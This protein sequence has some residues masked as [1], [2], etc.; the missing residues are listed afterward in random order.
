MFFR[1][2]FHFSQL[3]VESLGLALEVGLFIVLVLEIANYSF[4][5]GSVIITVTFL[6]FVFEEPSNIGLLLL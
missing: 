5:D 4:V 3:F 6:S 1:P 2:L